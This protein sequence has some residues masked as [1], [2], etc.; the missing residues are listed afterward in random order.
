MEFDLHTH[1]TASDGTLEPK[2][3]VDLA[4]RLGLKG[5]ALTDHDTID[6]LNEAVDYGMKQNIDVI[7][8]VEL[9]TNFEGYEIHLLGYLI[10][11][12]DPRLKNALVKM[13]KQRL[14]RARKMLFRLSD[15]GFPLDFGEIQKIAG[16]GVIGR[17]HLAVAMVNEGYVTNVHEAFSRFLGKGAPAYVPREKMSLREAIQLIKEVKGIPVLAH[18]GLLGS[19]QL[20]RQIIDCGI[21]GIE[22]EYPEHIPSQKEYL[23]R[24]CRDHGLIPTGGSDFHGNIR[25]IPM[26]KC[27]VSLQVV[28]QLRE[29]QEE[30]YD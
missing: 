16:E 11:W 30:Y 29:K 17:P 21:M 28:E 18:P 14:E 15:L 25:E 13:T 23:L 12:R 2:E 9:S 5:F 7:P 20:V 27:G 6:G 1:S 19:F 22:V 8:G 4:K 24:L 10:D 3:L 26:G